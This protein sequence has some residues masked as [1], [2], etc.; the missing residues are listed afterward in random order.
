MPEDRERLK[1]YICLICGAKFAFVY[2][3]ERHIAQTGHGE[4]SE[5]EMSNS[6]G[7]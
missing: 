2:D 3:K 5:K 4:F 6:D 1:W 7:V